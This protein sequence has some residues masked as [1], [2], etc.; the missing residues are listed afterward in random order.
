MLTL[1]YTLC[2][3]NCAPER[4]AEYEK[5]MEGL[6]DVSLDIYADRKLSMAMMSPPKEDDNMHLFLTHALKIGDE[7]LLDYDLGYV[8]NKADTLRGVFF[9]QQ[10]EGV[11]WFKLYDTVASNVSPA[12]RAHL[13]DFF[14]AQLDEFTSSRAAAK[15]ARLSVLPPTLRTPPSLTPPPPVSTPLQTYT[16][17][18]TELRLC[19]HASCR[20][21]M[22]HPLF[23]ARC[24][25][26]V[27]CARDCQT[28]AWKA[29]KRECTPAAK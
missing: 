18:Q 23:C 4:W 10:E 26:A 17:A 7:L 24:K 19:D 5:V 8:A 25:V 1:G 13:L 2:S 9:M 11:H 27:Y 29:H 22:P 16:C 12:V 21:L 6:Q 3:A 20:Q 14:E 15:A 28:A